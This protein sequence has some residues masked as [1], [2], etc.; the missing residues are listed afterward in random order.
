MT[1]ATPKKENILNFYIFLMRVIG[2]STSPAT[3]TMKKSLNQ[4]L[5]RILGSSDTSVATYC[6]DVL[7][8]INSRM[9]T[10]LSKYMS[11][12]YRRI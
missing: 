3:T 2:N 6:I 8:R 5:S 11:L 4:K 9:P 12:G 1:P 7:M 10:Y